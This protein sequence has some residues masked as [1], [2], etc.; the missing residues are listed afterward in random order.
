MKWINCTPEMV[1]DQNGPGN[2]RLGRYSRDTC[3]ALRKRRSDGLDGTSKWRLV[4]GT[5]LLQGCSR[6][7]NASSLNS[8]A[9]CKK[10][11]LSRNSLYLS[12]LGHPFSKNSVARKLELAIKWFFSEHRI[13]AKDTEDIPGVHLRQ[14][15]VCKTIP[16]S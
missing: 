14:W 10:T 9:D 13:S 1:S 5:K 8:N 2:C 15:K 7:K 11:Y 16:P 12:L 3:G 4:M 6:D